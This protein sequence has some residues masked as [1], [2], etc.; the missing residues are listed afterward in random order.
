M[1]LITQLLQRSHSWDAKVEIINSN[2]KLST[3]VNCGTDDTVVMLFFLL[4]SG[5][6]FIRN[7]IKGRF[8]IYPEVWT[9]CLWPSL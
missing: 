9:P 7:F 5:I 1:E 2:L 3:M 6:S 8:F 4:I